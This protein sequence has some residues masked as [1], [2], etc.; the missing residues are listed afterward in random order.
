MSIQITSFMVSINNIPRRGPAKMLI[1]AD[2][3][4]RDI[5][6][7]ASSVCGL[8]AQQFMRAVL[9]SAA[10]KVLDEAGRQ[11]DENVATN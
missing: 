2:R 11:Y 3:D 8:S 9:F 7:Y 4:V 10:K 5:I 1:E 6:N